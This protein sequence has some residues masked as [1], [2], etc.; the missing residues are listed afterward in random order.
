MNNAS[1]QFETGI[2]VLEVSGDGRAMGRAHGRAYEADVRRFAR[3]RLRLAIEPHWVGQPL[4]EETVLSVTGDCL[5]AHRDYSPAL[6]AEL[7]GLAA[8]AGIGLEEALLVGGFTD[9]VDTFY[10]AAGAA[11]PAPVEADQCT[12]FLV[13]GERTRTG[14]AL[15]GQTWDMHE[16]GASHALVLQGHP[17]DAPAFAV[18]TSAGAVGM[19]GMNEAGITIGINNLSGADGRIGVTWN[20][21]VR[22]AL[23]QTRFEDALDCI[24]QATLAGAH[25]YLLMDA[26]GNGVNVEATATTQV[27]THLERE[28]LAHTNHCV[29]KETRARQRTR[30]PIAQASSERRLERAYELLDRSGLDV[31]D[32]MA[33]T[34]DEQAICYQGKPPAHIATCGAV[35]ADPSSRRLWAVRGLPSVNRYVE[36]AVG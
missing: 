18:F 35:I 16:T 27:V 11:G 10:A 29:A 17:D 2:P 8:A 13:P 15:F 22:E 20:F 12:A 34:R 26:L 28:P 3:E 31:E 21:V 5:T 9:L 24:T 32:L 4:M 36:V 7:E 23:R 14:H 19:I 30:D 25:N 33:V 6:T 1:G